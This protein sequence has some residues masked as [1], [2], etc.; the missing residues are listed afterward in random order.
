MESRNTNNTVIKG[1][2]DPSKIQQFLVKEVKAN[3]INKGTKATQSVVPSCPNV[4]LD[5]KIPGT[6][7]AFYK[8]NR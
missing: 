6:N 4:D 2:Y 7:Y 1:V 5:S 3:A 8:L